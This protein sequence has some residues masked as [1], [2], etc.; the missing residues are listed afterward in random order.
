MHFLFETV[1]F[2]N[3]KTFDITIETL[4][5]F[6]LYRERH[7]RRTSDEIIY[8]KP[9]DSRKPFFLITKGLI[10][11][12][13]LLR[14]AWFDPANQS[15]FTTNTIFERTSRT[16]SG[17]RRRVLRFSFR[18]IYIAILFVDRLR[19]FFP[20]DVCP[21][22]AERLFHVIYLDAAA[23]FGGGGARK[24]SSRKTLRR[25][26]IPAGEPWKS[27]P[28]VVVGPARPA[29]IP[30]RP[31]FGRSPPLIGTDRP[32]S[33]AVV[34]GNARPPLA[35]LRTRELS[36][37]PILL[38]VAAAAGPRESADGVGRHRMRASF[39]RRTWPRARRFPARPVFDCRRRRRGV[40]RSPTGQITR[41]PA[42]SPHNA[43]GIT[44]TKRGWVHCVTYTVTENK[45]RSHQLFLLCEGK[46]SPLLF[47][48][49]NT[50]PNISILYI[51]FHCHTIGTSMGIYNYLLS[52]LV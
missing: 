22:P 38:A 23:F 9:F 14:R 36:R 43:S 51:R 18:V 37:R 32:R 45:T 6:E 2:Q 39:A 12:F 50:G 3:V 19:N 27:T 10:G 8:F 4:S 21:T 47:W 49:P 7:I 30:R 28:V 5:Y 11:R 48:P 42:R 16:D 34:K 35:A 41:I 46:G 40:V 24:V 26:E 13:G 15:F 1:F 52:T 31:D 25:R 17:V 44:H 33:G 29:P 20:P